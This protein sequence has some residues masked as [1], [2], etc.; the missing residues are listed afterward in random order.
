[1][2]TFP[3]LLILTACGPDGFYVLPPTADSAPDAIEAPDS[4]PD[5]ADERTPDADAGNDADAA[6]G[7]AACELSGPNEC[8]SV[9]QTYCAHYASCCQ[10]FPGNGKCSVGFDVPATCKT[11]YT[12]NGFDCPNGKY[13]RAVCAPGTSCSNSTNAASCSA[14]FVSSGPSDSN[15]ATCP[16]F[17]GQF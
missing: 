5:A 14:M 4:A 15:F 13:N 10:Q 17:W 16:A 1:M 2:R 8:T 7:D 6:K 3:I 12:Q 11:F 9:V